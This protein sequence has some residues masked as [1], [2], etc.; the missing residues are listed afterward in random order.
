MNL[1]E[2]R[3][4]IC[5]SI[6]SVVPERVGVKPH[7]G[8]FDLAEVLD[9]AEQAP[10]IRVAL[11][12]AGDQQQALPSNDLEFAAYILTKTGKAGLAGDQLLALTSVLL[13]RLEAFGAPLGSEECGSATQVIFR[14]L[15]QTDQGEE[16]IALGAVSWRQIVPLTPFATDTLGDFL[17]LFQT[18]GLSADDIHIPQV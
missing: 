2:A 16:G 1:L 18:T 4:A 8:R 12:S 11:L 6:S 17:R 13:A 9:Y 5:T 15:Y 3:T 7:P 14:N 10:C